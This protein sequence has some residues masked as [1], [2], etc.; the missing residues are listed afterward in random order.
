MKRA[1][2]QK[3]D[4]SYENRYLLDGYTRIA[5]TDEAGRG[6]WA[7]PVVAAAVTFKRDCVPA[8]LNDSKK[9]SEARRNALFDLIVASADV[10]IGV[11]DEA[12]IDE[13]NILHASLWAM[14]KAVGLLQ[15][16]PD[17]V[18]VDGN[19]L[20]ELNCPA[21][22]IVKGDSHS[23]SIA[24]ASIVA[25]VTRDRY[26]CELAKTYPDYGFERHK[27]YG[28]ALHQEALAEDW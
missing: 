14:S 21:R 17:F 25:K 19:K 2:S 10:G 3:P 23:L 26:M 16:K 22:A 6:P 8:G 27:G 4:F 12:K 11:A 20:P 7:G 24:A 18:L 9:L 15:K 1:D 28:T 5:G 13:L